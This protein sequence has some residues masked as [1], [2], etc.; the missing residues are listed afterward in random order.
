MYINVSYYAIT[1]T[2]MLDYNIIHV[3][4]YAYAY[5]YVAYQRL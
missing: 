5:A 3:F 2:D 1:L 4:N